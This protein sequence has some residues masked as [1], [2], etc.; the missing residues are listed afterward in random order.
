MMQH[1]NH[2]ER[3]EII[4]ASFISREQNNVDSEMIKEDDQEETVKVSTVIADTNGDHTLKLKKGPEVLDE[5]GNLIV[6][7]ASNYT[8]WAKMTGG[9]TASHE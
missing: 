6:N 3:E 2:G 1:S 9:G 4:S 8:S 5:E 7:P